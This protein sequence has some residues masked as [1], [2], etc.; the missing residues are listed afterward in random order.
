MQMK[1]KK[2]RN[3]RCEL[4]KN[5]LTGDGV[6]CSNGQTMFFSVAKMLGEAKV[7]QPDAIR[8]F[9]IKEKIFCKYMAYRFFECKFTAILR[10]D[11]VF[12]STLQAKGIL[13][14]VLLN[15]PNFKSR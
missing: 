7:D 1:V 12:L 4:N 14:T 8:I 11:N 2:S 9:I 10:H 3:N 15:V 5:I 13:A 6:G